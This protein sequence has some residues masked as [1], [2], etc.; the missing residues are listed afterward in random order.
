MKTQSVQGYVLAFSFMYRYSTESTLTKDQQDLMAK[1][2]MLGMKYKQ[3]E[4]R[5]KNFSIDSQ[6]TRAWNKLQILSQGVLV[7]IDGL[8]FVLHL[9]IKNPCKDKHKEITRLA[10]QCNK[11][12]IF[13]T[14]QSSIEAKKIVNKFY[15]IGE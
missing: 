3:N 7:E 4:K 2:K 10:I 9:L 5:N 12:L 13:S 11:E 15:G 1:L 6:L 14:D 8:P